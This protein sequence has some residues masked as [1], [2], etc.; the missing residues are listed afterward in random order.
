MTA[1]NLPA[2]RGETSGGVAVATGSLASVS[3]ERR[4]GSVTGSPAVNND[5]VVCVLRRNAITSGNI[6]LGAAER[7]R[8]RQGG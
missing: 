4:A 8:E 7:E 6:L 2:E 5:L 1:P 3:M